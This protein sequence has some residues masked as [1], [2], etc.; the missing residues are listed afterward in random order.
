MTRRNLLHL[1]LTTV[2]LVLGALPLMITSAAVLAV[3]AALLAA[4]SLG[5]HLQGALP[6][7]EPPDLPPRVS[8][9]SN[10]VSPMPSLRGERDR[11]ADRPLPGR[12]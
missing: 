4:V 10:P 11:A 6:P 9:G 7:G 1:S 3:P 12:R 5:M 8:A 2:A